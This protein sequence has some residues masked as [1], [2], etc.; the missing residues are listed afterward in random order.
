MSKGNPISLVHIESP[1][2]TNKKRVSCIK[3]AIKQ[4]KF[5]QKPSSQGE[6]DHVQRFNFSLI[7]T[8]YSRKCD[9]IFVMSVIKVGVPLQNLKVCFGFFVLS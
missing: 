6:K 3:R 5:T 4:N 7:Q 9:S 1:G 8:F 2:S